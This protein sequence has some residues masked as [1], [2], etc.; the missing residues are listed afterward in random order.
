MAAPGRVLA[1]LAV[2]MAVAAHGEAASVVVGLAKCGD[3][4]RKNMKAEA[5]FKGA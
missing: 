4:T 5:A 1:L 3:C 2:L